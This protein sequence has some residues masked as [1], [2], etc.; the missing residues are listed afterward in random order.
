MKEDVNAAIEDAEGGAR[1]RK[2]IG[3]GDPRDFF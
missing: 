2:L 3:W 1:C